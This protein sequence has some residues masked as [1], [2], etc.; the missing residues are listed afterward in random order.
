MTLVT[1][2]TRKA[3]FDRS[4]LRCECHNPACRHHRPGQRCPRGI[5]GD[6]WHVVIREE[7]AGEKL[8]NLLAVC[9]ACFKVAMDAG[10]IGE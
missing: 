4:G 1:E 5:R 3:L 7:G 8:W 2:S 10:G 9:P 6:Q